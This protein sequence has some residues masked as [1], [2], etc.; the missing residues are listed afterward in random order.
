MISDLPDLAQRCFAAAIAPGTPLHRV[1]RLEMK[2]VFVPNG[3][4]MP[5][6]ARQI[7]A[8]PRPGFVQQVDIGRGLMRISG[9]DGYHAAQRAES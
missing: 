8:P 6:A 1:E 9:S 7:L 5:M 2:G 4:E 3:T